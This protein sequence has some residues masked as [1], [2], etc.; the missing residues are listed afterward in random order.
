MTLM[1]PAAPEHTFAGDGT[2]DNDSNP[3]PGRDEDRAN[4][5]YNLPD[6]KGLGKGAKNVAKSAGKIARGIGPAAQKA[7]AAAQAAYAAAQA[8]ARIAAQAAAQAAA[9]TAAAATG[10][11]VGWLL[12]IV[13]IIIIII[14]ILG[15]TMGVLGTSTYSN[16]QLTASGPI[17]AKI[18]DKLDYTI[19]L[20]YPGTAGN[21]IIT[22]QIPAGTEYVN[23]PQAT[24]NPATNTVT[25]NMPATTSATLSLTLLATKDNNYIVNILK[26][27]TP[28]VILGVNDS[29]ISNESITPTPFQTAPNEVLKENNSQ[30]STL[31]FQLSTP[32]TPTIFQL[33]P[34]NIPISP[35]DTNVIKSCVVT[36]VGE[37][38]IIPSLPPECTS[39]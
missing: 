1:D 14:V 8:A 10:I 25:W 4:T 6:V 3:Y 13:V 7:R 28:N 39:F 18:G 15:K 5:A 32:V 16:Q 12:I 33:A 27:T 9:S 20:D 34:T 22:D 17:F 23:A 21:I 19:A 24:Y 2:E 37:P 35:Q 31:N 30:L 11:S 38:A 29:S 26:G 36:K